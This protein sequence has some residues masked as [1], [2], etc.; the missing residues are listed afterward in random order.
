MKRLF[1]CTLAVGGLSSLC[2]AAAAPALAAPASIMEREAKVAQRIDEGVRSGALQRAEAARL[3]D[4]LRRTEA[5]EGYYRRTHGLSAWERRDVERRLEV[6]N[7]R[8]AG[9]RRDRRRR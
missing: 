7:A 2:L 4:Q 5:L 1:A 9:H 6:L 3:R 8:L